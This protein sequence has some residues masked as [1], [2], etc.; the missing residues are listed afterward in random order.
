M[1]S[2]VRVG[3]DVDQGHRSIL[4]GHGLQDWV[5]D[6]VITPHGQWNAVLGQ[7]ALV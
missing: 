4:R 3:V 6:Q 1:F 5:A 2:C 7:Q